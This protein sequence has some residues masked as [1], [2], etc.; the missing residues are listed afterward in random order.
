MGKFEPLPAPGVARQRAKR[1]SWV[2]VCVAVL[3]FVGGFHYYKDHFENRVEE[4]HQRL[5]AFLSRP[6]WDQETS[7]KLSRETCE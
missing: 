1:R 4:L 3:L 6:L 7:S 5:D 2:W